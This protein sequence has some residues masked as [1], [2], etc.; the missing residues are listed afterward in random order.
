MEGEVLKER[1]KL[2]GKKQLAGSGRNGAREIW[3]LS[4]W[5]EEGCG[6]R[7][8]LA[9]RLQ[10]R[11]LPAALKIGASQEIHNH[12]IEGMTVGREG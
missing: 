9:C 10:E 3:E 6:S 5:V 1:C 8:N 7:A 2:A 12:L 4:I 11:L